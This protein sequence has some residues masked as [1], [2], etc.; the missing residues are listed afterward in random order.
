MAVRIDLAR[1]RVSVLTDALGTAPLFGLS[2]GGGYLVS[3]S[4]AAIREVAERD[5]PD[6]LGVS[7][8]LSLG[9][10][11]GRSTL[12]ERVDALP[13]GRD[14]LQVTAAGPAEAA[15][16]T[17][18]SLAAE[19]AAGYRVTDEEAASALV[20]LTSAAVHAAERQVRPHG[21]PRLETAP[22]PGAGGGRERKSLLHQRQRRR[23]RRGHRHTPREGIRSPALHLGAARAAGGRRLGSPDE[24]V[25]VADRRP[26][27]SDPDQG[28][29]RPALEP[30]PARL[31]GRRPRR[32]GRARRGRRGS[33]CRERSSHHGVEQ[34]A[35]AAA[36]PTGTSVRPA[37]DRGHAHARQ[38]HLRGF[39]SARL[40]EGWSAGAAAEA[41]YAFDRV[42]RW[43][44]TGLR[45]TS[46]TDDCSA[47]SAPRRSSTTASRSRA[48]SAMPSCHT[49]ES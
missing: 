38:G 6:P 32:G 44:S 34:A 18:A 9:W 4:V 49:G 20:S 46:S 37:V 8:F 30:A 24:D 14:F 23:A 26:L 22:R 16:L 33:I 7:S 3:N 12:I 35:G 5:T 11:A 28:L 19:R 47:R 10:T 39:L 43:G 42:A 45:R 40:S 2:H 36:R 29:R 17:P 31:E 21:W 15:H 1:D 13:G 48:T 41:F 25:R 27:Q